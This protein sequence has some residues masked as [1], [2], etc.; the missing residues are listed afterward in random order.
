MS[1]A[2]VIVRSSVIVI[3]WRKHDVSD[4]IHTYCI[5]G[6]GFN[7]AAFRPALIA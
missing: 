6:G 2:M 4:D 1:L 7:E 5:G 3:K